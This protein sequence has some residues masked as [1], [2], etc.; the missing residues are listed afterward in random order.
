MKLCASVA[1]PTAKPEN[2]SGKAKQT[3]MRYIIGL[4]FLFVTLLSCSTKSSKTKENIDKWVTHRDTVDVGFIMTYKI[5]DS[6]VIAD[7]IDN[8]RCIGHKINIVDEN[9]NED[10]TN[11]RQWCICMQDTADNSI[12]YFIS[13]WKTMFKGQV[14]GQRDIITIDNL[15]ALRV[16]LKSKNKKDPYRQLIYLKKY[17]TLF[18]IINIS[19]ETNKDFETF[20]NSLTIDETKKPN[21]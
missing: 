10:L 2:V 15:K 7:I 18:E 3:T 17:S 9:P 4:L 8:C 5:P 1:S 21:H 20:Y 11:T 12:E 19:E 14:I 16:T 13:S 6:L